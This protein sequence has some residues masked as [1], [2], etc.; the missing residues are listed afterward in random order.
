MLEYNPVVERDLKII[1][2]ICIMY[3]FN[4]ESYESYDQANSAN[5]F[6]GMGFTLYSSNKADKQKQK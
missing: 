2:A 4:K 1:N 5:S 6:C 3:L